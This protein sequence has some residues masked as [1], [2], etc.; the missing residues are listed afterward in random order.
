MEISLA[1]Y[2][3]MV[4]GYNALYKFVTTFGIIILINYTVAKYP[5]RFTKF[6]NSGEIYK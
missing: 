4:V 3:I 2:K 6:V 1:F 5:E